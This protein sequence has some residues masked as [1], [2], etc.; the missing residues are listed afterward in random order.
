[1]DSGPEVELVGI[2]AEWVTDDGKVRLHVK[3]DGV[4]LVPVVKDP[5]W[6]P[7]VAT[8][9]KLNAE[10][11]KDLRRALGAKISGAFAGTFWVDIEQE[12]L[13]EAVAR[14]RETIAAFNH[15]FPEAFAAH[16]EEAA[17]KNADDKAAEARRLS[18]QALID[19]ALRSGS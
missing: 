14:I 18:A 11:A 3:L 15:R 5:R 2:R 12:R 9:R 17:R 6:D 8:R 10:V 1:M 7:D 16:Q 13:R 19:E 4:D